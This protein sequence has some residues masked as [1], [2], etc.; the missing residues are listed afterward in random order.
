MKTVLKFALAAAAG[1]YLF[2]DELLANTEDKGAFE[3]AQQISE[4]GCFNPSLAQNTEC[5]Q[6]IQNFEQ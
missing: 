6:L 5:T 1:C 2:K 4:Q 3:I